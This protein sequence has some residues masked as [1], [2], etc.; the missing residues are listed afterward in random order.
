MKRHVAVEAEDLEAEEV[1]VAAASVEVP[2]EEA[3]SEAVVRHH[4]GKRLI[5]TLKYQAL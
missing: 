1:A 3:L 2:S 5:T 4:V